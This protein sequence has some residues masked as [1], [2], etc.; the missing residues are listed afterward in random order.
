MKNLRQ[1]IEGDLQ[2]HDSRTPEA[3]DPSEVPDPRAEKALPK[4]E[5]L[6]RLLEACIK[7][8]FGGIENPRLYSQTYYG[9]KTLLQEFYDEGMDTFIPPCDYR[10][11]ESGQQSK[12]VWS[13]F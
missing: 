12:S 4:I 13:S 6:R 1:S 2:D 3:H 9:T 7:S 5:E 11:T 10:E 8:N